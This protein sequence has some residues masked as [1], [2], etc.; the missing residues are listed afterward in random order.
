MIGGIQAS[1]SAVAPGGSTDVTIHADGDIEVTVYCFR[2]SPPPPQL[3]PCHKIILRPG[4]TAS[5]TADRLHFPP[6]SAGELQVTALDQSDGDLRTWVI[7][8][9]SATGAASG[10]AQEMEA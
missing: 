3:V 9:A 4:D 8:V 6:G 1:P 7:P 5:I 2:R 10:G